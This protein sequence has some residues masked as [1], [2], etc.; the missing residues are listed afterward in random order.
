MARF[1]LMLDVGALVS[2]F[3]FPLTFLAFQTPP[4]RTVWGK[5]AH[6]RKEREGGRKSERRAKI[7]SV[8]RA[9]K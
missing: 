2:F 7:A 5:E 3:S 9:R 4:S 8:R 1:L 6:F